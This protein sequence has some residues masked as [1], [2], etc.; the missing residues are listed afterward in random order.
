MRR[1]NRNE[2]SMGSMADIAFLLLIFFLVATTLE[3]DKGILRKLP[4]MVDQPETPIKERNILVVLV[5]RGNK[6][7]VEGEE[8]NL[9]ELKPKAKEFILN[10]NRETF[11]P[12]VYD[13]DID[14]F[15][16]VPITK[17]HVI[18]LQSDRGT[19]Y[20]M[21]I[22]V[23]NELAAAY[24]ELQDEISKN[25]FGVKYDELK[26][27]E[28]KTKREAIEKIYSN[29]VSEAEPKNVGGYRYVKI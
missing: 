27:K 8:I 16:L 3:T 6:L 14:Y 20:E 22:A 13:V 18:S 28:N 1:Y 11:L 19:S 7:M 21:Y 15:G 29:K 5:N 25:K 23:Q 4:P 12:E 17:K 2:I 24:N 10:N 26:G 9:R